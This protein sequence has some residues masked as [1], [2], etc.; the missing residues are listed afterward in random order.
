M[1]D[2]EKATSYFNGRDSAAVVLA[3]RRML[4]G[5]TSHFLPPEKYKSKLATDL[6]ELAK[7]RDLSPVLHPDSHN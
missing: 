4:E 3:A 5:L 2:Y 1:R 6:A 7:E